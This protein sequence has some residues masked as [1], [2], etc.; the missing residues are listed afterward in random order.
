MEMA[1]TKVL[2]TQKHS[3]Q[4]TMIAQLKVVIT[5]EKIAV[6]SDGTTCKKLLHKL[7]HS[8]QGQNMS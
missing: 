2:E 5:N 1:V 6:R 8:W 7:G 3:D 4:R